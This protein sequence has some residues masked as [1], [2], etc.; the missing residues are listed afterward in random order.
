MSFDLSKMLHPMT[1]NQFASVSNHKHYISAS[2]IVVRE[3]IRNAVS[4]GCKNFHFDVI[5]RKGCFYLIGSHDGEPFYS[6][7][8]ISHSL[9]PNSSYGGRGL[10]G[11]GGKLSPCALVTK[12]SDY[13]YGI[14]SR[15][16]EDGESTV[17]A[18][19]KSGNEDSSAVVLYV[20]TEDHSSEWNKIVN[21]VHQLRGQNYNVSYIVR[22]DKKILNNSSILKSQI[23]QSFHEY[24]PKLAEK[25]NVTYS[26]NQVLKFDSND[27]L[28]QKCINREINKCI[29][30]DMF[31]KMFISKSFE[32][33]MNDIPFY[34]ND[35][36]VN[37]SSKVKIH[38]GLG[39]IYKD[40]GHERLVVINENDH[41][42]V[43]S[44]IHEFEIPY[45]CFS[46][47]NQSVD[48][49][50]TFSERMYEDPI[51]V[52]RGIGKI[53]AILELPFFENSRTSSVLKD[54]NIKNFP[55]YKH[56]LDK[57]SERDEKQFVRR[58]FVLYEE[59][60]T[61]IDGTFQKDAN[62]NFIP[63]NLDLI[64]LST[65]FHSGLDEFF[66]TRQVSKLRSISFNTAE[67]MKE[68][69]D[70]TELSKSLNFLY[71]VKPD[72]KAELKIESGKKL[73]KVYLHKVDKSTGEMSLERFTNLN[74]N[75]EVSCVICYDNGNPIS[76][77]AKIKF[78]QRIDLLRKTYLNYWVLQISDYQISENGIDF[79]NV[80]EEEWKTK[81]CKDFSP[82]KEIV[83]YVD[84][85]KFILGCRVN[86]PKKYDR[87]HAP[88]TVKAHGH[89]E[90][91]D[92]FLKNIGNNTEMF[93]DENPDKTLYMN[94][95]QKIINTIFRKN[96]ML[97]DY[98]D[99]LWEKIQKMYYRCASLLNNYE[100]D[101]MKIELHEDHELFYSSYQNFL[102]NGMMRSFFESLQET[103][104]YKKALASIEGSFCE[105]EENL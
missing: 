17:V 64:D 47:Y 30:L 57:I 77:S 1:T 10:Q 50:N 101:N 83:I 68:S 91:T 26:V 12:K 25:T 19:L 44:G 69:Q 28:D 65:I 53:G 38:L 66:L 89:I 98:Q 7:E 46:F 51:H 79:K 67:R 4:Y 48:Y 24:M 74:P 31:K 29:S 20:E 52:G 86:V 33:E 40:S 76:S 84:G 85:Q 14:W 8:H 102:I 32:F 80:T 56:V 9:Y 11:N 5:E 27:N 105:D 3:Q 18:R 54:F 96:L 95:S 72:Q 75:E 42:E 36:R 21:Q 45:N 103:P 70:L 23:M 81:E 99:E 71:P 82:K 104:Q 62:K 93:I 60:V 100:S 94:F 22:F 13:F 35:Y 73:S 43:G 37:Y 63:V 61:K 97:T 92:R 39:L 41:R 88:A 55:E 59:V 2:M 15:T 6:K 87:P 16:A 78:N 58:P 49:R 34:T 90:R